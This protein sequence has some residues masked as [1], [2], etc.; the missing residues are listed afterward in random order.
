MPVNFYRFDD[1]VLMERLRLVVV[2]FFKCPRSV[3]CFVVGSCFPVAAR[4]GVAI[5]RLSEEVIAIFGHL[6]QIL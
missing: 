5:V 2:V 3:S 4:E 6:H 1:P